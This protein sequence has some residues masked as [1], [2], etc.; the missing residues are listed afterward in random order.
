MEKEE[1]WPSGISSSTHILDDTPFYLDNADSVNFME[2]FT[3]CEFLQYNWDF[4]AQRSEL[5]N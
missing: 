5:P 3:G 2:L 1:K 4:K